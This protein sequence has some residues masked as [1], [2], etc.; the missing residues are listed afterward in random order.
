M[1]CGVLGVFVEALL[2]VDAR[3][4]DDGVLLEVAHDGANGLAVGGDLP[5]AGEVVQRG[6]FLSLL[7]EKTNAVEE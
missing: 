6:A 4:L 2:A 7:V 3:I 5:R 1:W